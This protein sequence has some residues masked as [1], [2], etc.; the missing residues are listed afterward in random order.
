M[1]GATD[2]FADGCKFVLASSSRIPREMQINAQSS[3]LVKD[4]IS[5][6]TCSLLIVLRNQTT[7]FKNTGLTL[8]VHRIYFSPRQFELFLQGF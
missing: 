1:A 3:L 5:D 2:G 7:F 6:F 4:Q 8:S